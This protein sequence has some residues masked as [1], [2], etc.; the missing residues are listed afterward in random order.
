MGCRR[1]P[2][3]CVSTFDIKSE[4]CISKKTLEEALESHGATALALF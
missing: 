2:E 3:K 4:Q 1:R